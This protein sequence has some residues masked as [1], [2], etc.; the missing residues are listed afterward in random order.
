MNTPFNAVG[1]EVS[2]FG[3]VVITAGLPYADGEIHLGGITSTYLPADI[4]AR[5]FRLKGDKVVFACATDDFGTPILIQAE[6]E[7]KS[8]EAFVAH[9]YKADK[10]DFDN[11]GIS[12]DIFHQTS[13]NENIQFTQNIFKKLHEKGFI[14]N[15]L[16]SQPYCEKCRKVL[17]DRYVKGT[18]PHCKATDQYSDGCEE[19]GK[20]FQPGEIKDSHC[21]LCGSKP[22]SNQSEHY[23]FK[24][25]QFSDALKK[26][27]IESK[28][29][30]PE[31]KNYVL[32]WIST[33]LED[34][35]ITRDITWGVP[36]PLDEAK[37]KVLYNWFDNHLCYIST[38]LKHLSDKG[39]DGKA[40]WN[41]SRIYHFIGKDIVYHHYLF[42]PAM[43]LGAKEFKL[44]DFIPTRGHMQLQGMKFSKSRRWYVSLREFLNLFP[45]DY[46]RYYLAAITPYSQSDVKF[47]WEDFQ[48]RINNELIANIG[49]FIHRTLTFI[50][51]NCSGDVP[52]ARNYEKLDVQFKGEIE[53]I[54]N[55]AGE[56]IE[57]IELNRGLKKILEFSSFCNQYFQRKE[58]WTKT[59][60]T[61]TCLYL[62]ANAVRSFAILLE[63]YLPFSAEILW[64][65]LNLGGS[66][67][68]QNWDSASILNVRSGHRINKPRI[69]FRRI[70]SE[71]IKR[72]KEKLQR[73][74]VD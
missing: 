30:Q 45:A 39:I 18:C 55:N 52:E 34:W 33:G 27:L 5:F 71:E 15:Q 47:E 66:I 8:P 70:E 69:L 44:P 1:W 35:D 68:Q 41:S 22:V 13:S 73:L 26:W 51:S 62:C 11:L 65:Q 7:R 38:T 25:S 17:P 42:L 14:F 12:F 72:E 28:S 31:V 50:W 43:R 49:N 23:F 64:Q 59:E 48:S 53:T 16:V 4:L 2:R 24:L 37:G 61:S 36:I 19:C 6:K 56:E 21:A 57:R 40:F 32:D 58:P 29:L 20:V 46:L 10:K 67:H 3:K 9:W 63:P 74:S 60:D 54:A